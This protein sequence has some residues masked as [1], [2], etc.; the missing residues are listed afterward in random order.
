M[1]KK[2]LNIFLIYD[3]KKDWEE[4]KYEGL[5]QLT[6]A[7]LKHLAVANVIPVDY[8]STIDE[9]NVE[10]YLN[11]NNLIIRRKLRN[12]LFVKYFY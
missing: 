9:E 10:K 6:N 12:N 1:K 5:F 7:E 4:L 8:Y 3:S 11:D 2:K